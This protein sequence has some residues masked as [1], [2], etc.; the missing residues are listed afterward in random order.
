MTY[1]VLPSLKF[2]VLAELTEQ[3]DNASYKHPVPDQETE[4]PDLPPLPPS[5]PFPAEDE[6]ARHRQKHKRKHR[7]Q[8]MPSDDIP[9]SRISKRDQDVEPAV[10]ANGKPAYSVV[11]G[12][13]QP[14]RKER[15][16]ELGSSR[17]GERHQH[18]SERKHKH[19]DSD[20]D[21]PSTRNRDH[22]KD[23][24]RPD[25][26][27]QRDRDSSKRHQEDDRSDRHRSSKGKDRDE[28]R[29]RRHRHDDDR[30]HRSRR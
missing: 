21:L 2:S 3:P 10:H 20:A 30:Q 15:A 27:R 8:D 19:R 22:H 9:S 25:S 7:D 1:Q 16:E 4:V 13:E 18:R 5:E 24:E 11:D 26:H 12:D 17:E 14:S 28:D 29:S 6:E 23:R